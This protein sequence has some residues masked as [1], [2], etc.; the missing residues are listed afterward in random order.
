MHLN[1][2]KPLLFLA[3][4]EGPPKSLFMD[5]YLVITS[6]IDIAKI[7]FEL[8]KWRAVLFVFVEDKF[9]PVNASESNYKI[10]DF[11]YIIKE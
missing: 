11:K 7:A 8:G 3:S 5:D 9:F 1:S 10:Q 6:P 2:N 4:N